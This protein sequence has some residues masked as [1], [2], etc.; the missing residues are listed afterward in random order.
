VVLISFS[1]LV[2]ST[3]YLLLIIALHPESPVNHP[4]VYDF[5]MGSCNLKISLLST[6]QEYLQWVSAFFMAYKYH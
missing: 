6:G 5:V 3:I 4:G 2:G 1:L